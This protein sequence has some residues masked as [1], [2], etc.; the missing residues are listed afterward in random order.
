MGKRD[1]LILSLF[2]NKHGAD[3]KVA[4]YEKIE[5]FPFR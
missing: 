4:L 3:P 5:V 1:I 2:Q